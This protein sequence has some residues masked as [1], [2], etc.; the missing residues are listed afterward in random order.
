[1]ACAV[2]P[3]AFAEVDPPLAWAGVGARAAPT[4]AVDCAEAAPPPTWV[5]SDAVAVP[6]LA[7]RT[8]SA[9]TCPQGPRPRRSC[10]LPTQGSV[11]RYVQTALR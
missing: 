10:P 5:A 7:G 4:W 6:P 1:M 2:V 9:S 11:P 3:V 8:H